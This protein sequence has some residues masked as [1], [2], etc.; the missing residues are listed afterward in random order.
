M[1]RETEAGVRAPS[2]CGTQPPEGQ[3][4]SPGLGPWLQVSGSTLP[5]ARAS[6]EEGVLVFPLLRR[7][8]S[9]LLSG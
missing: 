8:V 5:P 1:Q 9:L 4:A 3:L 6:V 2:C 7:T